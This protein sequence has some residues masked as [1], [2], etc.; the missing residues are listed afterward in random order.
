[1]CSL[2]KKAFDQMINRS[3]LSRMEKLLVAH[4][5]RLLWSR[6]GSN[7]S[8]CESNALSTKLSCP[9]RETWA[10]KMA[11]LEMRPEREEA[12]VR[13]LRSP[14]ADDDDDGCRQPSR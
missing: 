11:Q 7:R 2:L 9:I 13:V 1:M 3:I 4:V 5:K 12:C 8:V 14:V 10:F 6:R